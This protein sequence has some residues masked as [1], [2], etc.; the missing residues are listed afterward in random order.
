MESQFTEG[1]DYF[2][3]DRRVLKPISSKIHDAAIDAM[4]ARAVQE[5]LA[6]NATYVVPPERRSTEYFESIIGPEI[7]KNAVPLKEAGISID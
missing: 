1:V 6:N 3:F 7:E 4:G 2:L 5:A